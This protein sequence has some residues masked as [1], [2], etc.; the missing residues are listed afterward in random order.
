MTGDLLIVA[1]N[2][3]SLYE[4]LK[5]DFEADPEVRVVMD[6]RQTERRQR[7]EAWAAERRQSERRVRPPLDEKFQTVGFAV[8]EMGGPE[9]A[10]H[11]P[12]RS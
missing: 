11:T 5:N 3:R 6:R 12:Q 7:M 1:R 9:M 4:Y 8:I 2:Q 10:P